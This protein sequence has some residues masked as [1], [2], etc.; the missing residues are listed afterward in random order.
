MNQSQL[1]EEL[2]EWLK[3]RGKTR[4]DLAALIGVSKRTV[5][6]WFSGRAMNPNH[7]FSLKLLIN[8]EPQEREGK[9]VLRFSEKQMEKLREKFSSVEELELALKSF[10]LGSLHS[11]AVEF[12]RSYGIELAKSSDLEA[13]ENE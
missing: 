11:E 7:A 2:R 12:V 10:I 8:P 13:A 4:Q 9:I 3:S 6:N 1:I 5:D